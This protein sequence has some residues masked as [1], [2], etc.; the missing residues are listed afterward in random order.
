VPVAPRPAPK[1]KLPIGARVRYAGRTGE[2]LTY[3]PADRG[4]V[5]GVR[6]DTGAMLPDVAE[7]ELL[8]EGA[9]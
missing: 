5:Y 2:V 7:A 8:A 9:S 1:P 3:R 6:L 4:V